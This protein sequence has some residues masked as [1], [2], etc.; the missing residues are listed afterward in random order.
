MPDDLYGRNVYGV[1]TPLQAGGGQSVPEFGD[2]ASL[3]AEIAYKTVGFQFREET[4]QQRV[5]DLLGAYLAQGR[6]PR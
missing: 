1:E 5:I 2:V 4:L 6:P 3:R